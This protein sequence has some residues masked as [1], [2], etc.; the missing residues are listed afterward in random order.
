MRLFIHTYFPKIIFLGILLIAL[1]P[2]VVS[3]ETVFPYVVGRSLWFRGIIYCIT[4]L[5]LL[6]LWVDRSYIPAKSTLILTLSLF[7]LFQ[8]LAGLFGLSPNASFWGNFERMEGVV[9]YTHWLVFAVIAFSTIRK[10]VSWIKILKINTII[11]M[12]VAMLGLLEYFGLIIPVIFNL[13]LFPLVSTP[14]QS[15]TFGERIE[16]TI[17]NPVYLAAYLSL[18]IFSSFGLVSRDF[19]INYKKSL[20]HTYLQL[21]LINRIYIIISLIGAP[22][23]LFTI[24]TSG[25]RGALIGIFAGLIFIFTA[26]LFTNERLKKFGYIGISFFFMVIILYLTIQYTINR[27]EETLR[28]E[29]LTK[30][31][32]AEIF[33]LRGPKKSPDTNIAE[34]YPEISKNFLL[35]DFNESPDRS[36]SDKALITGWLQLSDEYSLELDAPEQI[37]TDFKNCTPIMKLLRPLG[38]GFNYTLTSGFH[39]GI[40]GWA[41]EIALK[42]FAENPLFGIGPENFPVLHY[43]Y[44]DYEKSIVENGHLDRAHNRPLH[45]LATSGI[46]GLSGMVFLWICLFWMIIKNIKINKSENI[47]WISIGAV[48]VTFLTTSLFMFSISSTYLQLLLIVAVLARSEIGFNITNGKF[49]TINENKEVTFF[50]DSL[51]IIFSIL[52]LVALT[53]TVRNYV[54]KPFDMAKSIPPVYIGES[55]QEMY[56]NINIFPPLSNWAR[57]EM[58]MFIQTILDQSLAESKDFAKD[59]EVLSGIIDK[60]YEDGVKL[61]P[62]NFN[63][64][65]SAA[66]LFIKLAPN[67]VKYL[68]K[69]IE[70]QEI[71]EA[72]SPT[73]VMVLEMK[74][75][76]TMLKNDDI[77]AT[78][79]VE[80]WR[81]EFNKY[82][83]TKKYAN[84][85]DESLG[86]LK[87]EIIP[88][89]ELDCKN[90]EYPDDKAQFEDS[91]ALYVNELDDGL[92]VAIKQE[93]DISGYTLS[94]GNVV[95]INYTGWLANGCIFDSSY[96]SGNPLTFTLGV[97]R[98]IPG[99]ENG[100]IGRVKGDIARIAIPPELAYG[101]RGITGLIPPNSTIYFEVEILDVEVLD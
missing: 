80:I 1:L 74:I 97:G 40:R 28:Y 65:F 67:E 62:N 19:Q 93:G 63:L 2:L 71:L 6:L 88:E 81:E 47:F 13:E 99:M 60:L 78:R 95:T 25:S 76:T 54:Y 17:G 57:I 91:N 29:V 101:N 68:D 41:W 89:W 44:I 53:L 58:L 59:Y 75:R 82:R 23:I 98:A 33:D 9:E 94:P 51:T 34:I 48:L 84:F 66:N 15:Y 22:I 83:E 39:F 42:G 56:E 92:K 38:T 49:S 50:R 52:A 8:A 79:L 32:P 7:V 10:K 4:T 77:N 73:S 20:M 30:Y 61:T 64:H 16:S 27:Q 26:V 36:C 37:V 35:Q 14:E 87:G 72:L 43:Q 90:N 55:V 85:W 24:I 5:W 69:A 45:I 31:F 96:I 46:I 12:A 11:G 3:P 21:K 70:V 86:I 18:I 100:L